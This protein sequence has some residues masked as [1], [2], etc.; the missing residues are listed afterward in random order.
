[1]I[2]DVFEAFRGGRIQGTSLYAQQTFLNPGE[3]HNKIESF[4]TTCN[5]IINHH[6]L[7]PRQSTCSDLAAPPCQHQKGSHYPLC[8]F[9]KNKSWRSP[10]KFKERRDRG[11]KYRPTR[12]DG[13]SGHLGAS[14]KPKS[15]QW[16]DDAWPTGTSSTQSWRG[17]GEEAPQ[18]EHSH[19][20]GSDDLWSPW[21]GTDWH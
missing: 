9:T 2:S 18:S 5:V 17:A 15:W 6:L 1:M 10:A 21:I 20:R 3:L 8:A 7:A 4:R 11:E 12:H 16:N 19:S 13:E 14:S